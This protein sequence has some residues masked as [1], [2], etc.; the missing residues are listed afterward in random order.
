M[1]G[2]EEREKLKEK[3]KED[4]RLRKAFLERV[5][6]LNQMQKLNSALNSMMEGLND[7]S[8]E[9]IQRLNQDAA[10]NEAKMDMGFESA[11]ESTLSKLEQIAQEAEMA[12]LNA[13]DLVLKM[14]RELGL[15]P[16]VPISPEAVETEEKTLEGPQADE[17][18][19]SQKTMGD[20]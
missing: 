10:L 3:Y 20:F 8:D 1:S 4:L 13:Q 11:A 2:E 12:R 7:D 14:K 9:W 18:A 6:N 17:S 16:E 19:Q 15:A 5:K